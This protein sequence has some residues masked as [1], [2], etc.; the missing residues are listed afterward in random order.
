MAISL[1]DLNRV[2]LREVFKPFAERT[3]R[4]IGIPL[5][6]PWT[7]SDEE[8]GRLADAYARAAWAPEDADAADS[9]A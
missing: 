6:T 4:E 1:D 9:E 5:P 8:L 2:T 7:P 3:M